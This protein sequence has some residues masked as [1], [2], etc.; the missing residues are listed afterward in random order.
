MMRHQSGRL[1]PFQRELRVQGQRHPA[2]SAQ[3]AHGG[4]PGHCARMSDNGQRGWRRP[5]ER[6]PV[7][8]ASLQ[9]SFKS[10]AC[11]D[12]A[13]H[14]EAATQPLM[15]ARR[16]IPAFRP[17]PREAVWRQVGFPEL[18]SV[19]RIHDHRHH[20]K[21]RLGVSNA[22]AKRRVQDGVRRCGPARPTRVAKTLPQWAPDMIQ[23][24]ISEYWG[25]QP[26]RG[27]KDDLPRARTAA[28]VPKRN[29]LC[30]SKRPRLPTGRS[31]IWQAAR[32]FV[33]RW[34]DFVPS[35]APNM[36]ILR[37]ILVSVEL[38]WLG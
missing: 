26:C 34:L 28:N 12:A 1:S 38:T 18:G 22:G 7:H 3:I 29:G 8:V 15:Q 6:N 27:P 16:F 36:L 31:A 19:H 25:G 2:G 9:A 20:R 5:L 10:N 14:A 4:P 21:L 33:A 13:T 37:Q 24:K 30:E 11:A 17:L 32:C 35:I 23:K